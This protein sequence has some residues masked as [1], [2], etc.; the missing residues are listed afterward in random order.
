[1]TVHDGRPRH[2]GFSS[3]VLGFDRVPFAPTAVPRMVL[4]VGVPLAL[5]AATGRASLLGLVAL[6]S[7]QAELNDPGGYVPARLR[8]LVPLGFVMLV[9]YTTG[10]LAAPVAAHGWAA[11]GVSAALAAVG[12][13]YVRTVTATLGG[14][15]FTANGL[16]ALAAPGGLGRL[17]LSLG[18]LA[19]GWLWGTALALPFPVRSRREAVRGVWRSV[20]RLLDSAGTARFRDRAQWAGAHLRAAGEGAEQLGAARPSAVRA[21]GRW[22][23][24]LTDLAG[25]VRFSAMALREPDASGT[26]RTV[27]RT[28]S[29][30]RSRGPDRFPDTGGS[31]AERLDTAL[32]TARAGP[33]P[34]DSTPAPPLPRTPLW[35]VVL[36]VGADGGYTLRVT[37]VIAAAAAAGLLLR[38]AE[39]Y[40]APFSA[41]L[42]LRPDPVVIRLRAVQRTLGTLVGATVFAALFALHPGPWGA[43]A[44]ATAA[45]VLVPVGQ[46]RNYAVMVAG[47]TPFLL[48]VVSGLTTDAYALPL[49]RLVD[50]T[51][52]CAVVLLLGVVLWPVNGA[53]HVARS[54]AAAL[55][56]AAGHLRVLTERPTGP[57]G[58]TPPGVRLADRQLRL[59]DDTVRRTGL[60]R[61]THHRPRHPDP[62]A[63]L[64]SLHRL[65]GHTADLGRAAPL[66][67]PD[68]VA[69]EALAD[70][71]D[72]LAE[73]VERSR[74]DPSPPPAP[75]PSARLRPVEA[76][77]GELYA[78]WTGVSGS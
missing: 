75:C 36:P 74:T 66:D 29:R 59:L 13:S 20:A 18:L 12:S 45:A 26:A 49:N 8:T 7:Y 9:G 58:P 70:R 61:V 62:A 32:R 39:W 71:L 69:V 34:G 33:P 73:A 10:T 77:V 37:T 55:R 64:P 15:T 4:A 42:V 5:A 14:L 30:T 17:P 28:L 65:F 11:V 27:A 54:T 67:D 48:V 43:A 35:R 72:S 2:P 40:W 78:T 1:M 50:V 57:D 52:G 19:V 31:L 60:L 24:R 3:A 53:E 47:L 22:L 41:Y 21:E 44:L 46:G 38:T 63:L 25:L 23:A 68:R 76:V 16:V 51:A 6:G 56:A